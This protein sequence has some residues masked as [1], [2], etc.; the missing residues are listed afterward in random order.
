MRAPTRPRLAAVIVTTCAL[1][2]LGGLARAADDGLT[3]NEVATQGAR[4]AAAAELPTNLRY[5]R[6]RVAVFKDGYWEEDL[7]ARTA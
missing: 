6:A 1:V 4:P 3:F 2:A 5:A 7:F